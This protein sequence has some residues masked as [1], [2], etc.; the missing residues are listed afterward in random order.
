MKHWYLFISLAIL[1]LTSSCKE[2]GASSLRNRPVTPDGSPGSSWVVSPN[3]GKYM[4]CKSE[5]TLKKD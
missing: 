2:R 5:V 3:Q 4:D 1:G